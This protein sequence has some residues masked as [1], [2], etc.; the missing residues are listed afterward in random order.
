MGDVSTVKSQIHNM[1]V[2][3]ANLKIWYAKISKRGWGRV[4]IYALT[5]K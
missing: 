5:M 2:A 3:L 4:G 1:G